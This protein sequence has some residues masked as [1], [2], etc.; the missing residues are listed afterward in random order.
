MSFLTR[1]KPSLVASLFFAADCGRVPTQTN[2]RF[3]PFVH[4]FRVALVVVYGGI[5]V[6][7]AVM[8]SQL[9]PDSDVRFTYLPVGPRRL[10]VRQRTT[11]ERSICHAVCL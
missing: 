4:K 10:V 3:Y 11:S 7:Y 8:G 9:E 2:D 6:F 1:G 5:L